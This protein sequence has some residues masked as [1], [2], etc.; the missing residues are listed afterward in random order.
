MEKLNISLIVL[1][2]NEE[3]NLEK[4]LK[5]VEGLVSE[6]IVVDSG[7]TDRTKEISEKFGAK[8]TVHEFKNQAQQ[9]NWALDNVE[10]K[11]DWIIRLDADEGLL[12]ELKE[13]IG[14][15][16]IDLPEDVNGLVICRRVYFMGRWI[17]H[18]GYYPA[19]FLRMFRKGTARYEEREVDEHMVLLAGKSIMLDNDFFDDNK[20]SL[21][22]WIGKQ[23]NHSS[24]EVLAITAQSKNNLLKARVL[25]GQAERKR[26]LKE[27]VFMGSPMFLRAFLYFIYRYFFRLGFLDGKE[28]LIFHFLSAF[29][30]RFLIDAKIFEYKKVKKQ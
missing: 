4:C 30:Y 13:E 21:E 3:L 12:P 14:K 10:I 25:G 18:G 19:W 24:R 15:K 2:R 20:Q 17:K 27:K 11:G 8:F 7:S 29:W 16:L 1:T 9:F 23:N 26:W 22:W 6:I 28:G 5:S